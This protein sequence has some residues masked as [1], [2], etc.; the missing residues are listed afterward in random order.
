M[1]RRPTGPGQATVIWRD[2]VERLDAR[3]GEVQGAASGAGVD[4]WLVGAAQ[5]GEQLVEVQ[6]EHVVEVAVTIVE[7]AR[8]PRPRAPRCPV[9]NG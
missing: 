2:F 7:V 5:G 6:F 9:S 8:P 4:R 1:T 3:L